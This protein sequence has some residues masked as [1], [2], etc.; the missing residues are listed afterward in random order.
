MFASIVLSIGLI[1]ATDGSTT[2]TDTQKIMGAVNQANVIFDESAHKTGGHR[3]LI[4]DRDVVAFPSQ[5]KSYYD[6]VIDLIDSGTVITDRIYIVFAVSVE[7]CGVTVRNLAIVGPRCWSGREV[8]HETIHAMGGVDSRAPH[9]SG[10]GH[11]SEE[12]D[13]MCYDDGYVRGQM[14]YLCPEDEMLLDCN[15][16]DYYNTDPPPD[17]F[18]ALHPEA[19]RALDDRLRREHDHVWL[20][21]A[22]R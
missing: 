22:G 6:L 7:V 21:M 15:N 11:C 16:D 5:A 9:A 19:N 1:L 2:I 4:V 3:D 18:L 13:V 20:P 8:A 17:S 14:T 12:H 10:L